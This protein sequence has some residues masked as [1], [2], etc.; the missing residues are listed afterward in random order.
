MENYQKLTVIRVKIGENIVV[1][2]SMNSVLNNF[3]CFLDAHYVFWS[4]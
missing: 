1:H 3:E 4:L 2:Q